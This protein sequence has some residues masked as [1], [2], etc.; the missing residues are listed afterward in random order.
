M[1]RLMIFA[2]LLVAANVF[3]AGQARPRF[4]PTPTRN[5]TTFTELENA[6]IDA[7]QKH[8]TQA[9]DRIVAPDFELRAAAAPA[10]PTARA[11]SI[12][13]SFAL[14]PFESHVS[15]M[16]VHEYPDL[17]V[18][19]FLWSIAPPK[20]TNLV[21]NVF[22]VDTWKRVEGNWQVV[23]RYAAPAANAAAIPGFVQPSVQSLK[24]KI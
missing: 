13:Q 9:I 19:S 12:K 7:V 23:V 16:A 14:P 20:G 21:Q 17:M 22:V 8:D 15:Q 10:V 6:W 2:G 5:V 18:V 3:A 11:D 24:K 4:V 1:K